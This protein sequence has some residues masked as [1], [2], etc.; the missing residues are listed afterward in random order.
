VPTNPQQGLTNDMSTSVF[1]IPTVAITATEPLTVI[2]VPKNLTLEER[3]LT[4][5]AWISTMNGAT[6]SHLELVE[7]VYN[8]FIL[9]IPEMGGITNSLTSLNLQM[10]SPTREDLLAWVGAEATALSDEGKKL[11]P[12][13]SRV[14]DVAYAVTREASVYIALSSILF[15]IGKQASESARASV[16]DNRPDAL[17]RRFQVP[18]E[19]QVIL[20]G[21]EAGPDR[22][23]LEGVYNA[24]SNYTEVRGVITTFFLAVKRQ[25]HHLPL[26]LEIMMNNFQL[27]R[28]A[29]MTHLDAIMRLARS[30]PWTMRVPELQP[31]YH[32]FL[33]DLEK[34]AQVE[35]DVRPYHRLLV[36]QSQYLF[37][38]SELRPLVAV[39][40]SFHEEVEKTFSGYVYNK[41]NYM[42]L[43]EKV[44]GYAPNYKPTSGLAKLA[45]LLDV[46]EVELPA[47]TAKAT[48]KGEETV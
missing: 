27:M 42:G 20:P 44:R 23:V 7:C 43:I 48:T 10:I 6:P 21:R 15:C 22:E 2:K 3:M 37:L 16:L 26:R 29:G 9:G 18:E 32:K 36:P 35:E 19:D 1:N 33:A 38:S 40:G 30:H 34:Y 14:K 17:L 45:A 13:F 31:F 47:F 12:L 4:I 5:S 28:G 8:L 24:F 25:G 46:E 41:A 11:P 39:A